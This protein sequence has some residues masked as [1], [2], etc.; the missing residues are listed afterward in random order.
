MVAAA[1]DHLLVVSLLLRLGAD[2]AIATGEPAKHT[3]L[4]F[5]PHGRKGITVP[6]ARA[7]LEAGAPMDL[8]W[9]KHENDNGGARA[10]ILAA[11]SWSRRRGLVALRARLLAY[12]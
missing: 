3:A 4:S 2:P 12:Y 11:W 1:N 8:A 7:L 5:V 9:L 10:S 6:I